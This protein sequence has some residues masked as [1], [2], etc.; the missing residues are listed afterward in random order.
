MFAVYRHEVKAYIKSLLIWAVCVGGI[1]F[2]CIVLFSS[3]KESIEGMA[4]SFSSMG[5]FADAFGMSQLSIATLTGFYATEVGTVHALGG[6]MFAAIISTGM[7]SKEEDGHT[8]EYLFSLPIARYK[9]LAAKWCAILTQIIFF[10]VFCVGLYLAGITAL[11][12]E[13]ARREF[14]LYH[15]MQFLM[16]VEIA[17]ISFALSAMMRKNK[18]GVGLGVVLL[19]Y[20]CDMIARVIPD[21]SKYKAVSPFSYANAAD[22]LSTGEVE[23]AATGIGAVILILSICM[24]F[25]VYSKRDLAA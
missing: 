1:G 10:N 22:I 8:S 11:G 24:A 5:A 2:A 13:M 16:Q 3:M 19:L 6:A 7:L 4:E 9:V 14:F 21:L 18:I 15:A 23:A 17:A 25:V 20:A 12:E